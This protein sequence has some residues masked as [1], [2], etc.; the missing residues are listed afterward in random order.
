MIM[1]DLLAP[2]MDQYI[3]YSMTDDGIPE[4]NSLAYVSFETE[5]PDPLPTQRVA[6]VLIEPR[7]LETTGNLAFRIDLIRSLQRFKGDLRADG[8]LTRFIIADLYRGPVHKDGRIVLALRR[9][10]KDVRASFASF[11]GAILIGNFPEASLVRR[12]SWCPGFLDPRQL[13]VG[14]ELVSSRAEIVLA[15][16][17]GNWESLYRQNDFDA[18]D[19]TAT[20][21]AATIATGWFDGESVR[22]CNFTATNFTV[23]RSRIF[24]DAFYLDDAIYQIV[25]HRTIPRPFLHIL[26]NQAEQNNEVD[27]SD[28]SLVNI[29]SR[30]DISISRINA[31]RVAV[32]PNPA[33]IGSGGQTFLDAEGA[34]QLV[35]SPTSLFDVRSQHNELFNSH[36]IDLE[37]RLML[38]YFNRNHRFRNGAFSNLPFRGAVISGTSDFNPDSYEGL[39]NNAATDF[40]PCVKIANADLQQ[41]V[42]FHKTPAVLKYIIAH[43][44]AR[45]SEFR[46]GYDIA[47]F[48]AEVGGVPFRWI[49]RSGQYTP[50]FEGMGG[51]A[52][53][54]THRAL[55]HYNTLD[56]AGGCL[57][58]HGGCDVNSVDETQSDAYT[59]G[60]YALWN[61][62]E[63]ILWYTNCVA[64]FSRAK[65]FNDAP[66][67]FTDGYRLSD[68]ANF[69]SCCRS[70]FNAQANDGGL[71][72]YNIQRKR[73][74]FWSING[75][76]TVRLRNK[77]GLG[78]LALAETLQSDRVHP[79]RAWIDGWNYDASVS[80]IKGIGDIDADGVDEF[81][82]TSEWG[83]GLLK[84]N[85]SH[86]QALMTAPRDTWFGGWRYDATINRGRDRIMALRNFTGTSKNEIMIWSSWGITTLEYSDAS[87]FPT[88]IHENGARLG[89]WLVNTADNVYCGSGQFGSD[90][91]NDMVLTS[92]WGMGII[93]LQRGTHV[94]MLPN[95]T[96]LGGWLLNSTENTIHLIAD[97]DGD[98]M[99]EILISSPWGIGL[100]KIMDGSLLAVAMHAN[101][102]NLEG[103]E[104]NN[105]HD[106]A[107]ADNLQGGTR[108][109]IV[110]RDLSGVHLLSFEGNKLVRLAFAGHGIRIDG[111]MIDSANNRLQSAGDLNGD[112]RAE[113]IIRS[114]WGVGIMGLDSTNHFRCHS[115]SPFGSMLQEWYLQSG[116]EIVGS[117]NFSGGAERRELLIAK[118]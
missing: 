16:L 89:G 18:E 2:I 76:W 38:S 1:S 65:G 47:T 70:Y 17:S 111:W 59:S 52:D 53:I 41:Y 95:G 35:N 113:L 25:E 62:A 68:R 30:P 9:F 92:P 3:D 81:V 21:D 34:P 15:D 103:Y 85:G 33:L 108:K 79:N 102:E 56:S 7:L 77:N 115:M 31:Y 42:Q 37:R 97:L 48:T 27:L 13:V 100:L 58:I 39:V 109:Q 5:Y 69:G 88:R 80:Q 94:H 104:V 55:W 61:N 29:L 71:T 75:D 8:L 105:T 112:G 60:R 11:E 118:A 84:Y 10:F 4:I 67:G 64:I 93:S 73:A 46:G 26:L 74:Y 91:R 99:D 57:I 36:D 107:L 43:S 40:Q 20:P 86:F 114:S 96:R 90:S 63:G 50:S 54:F 28:R 106:F 78:I 87:L 117:G 14:T 45:Y 66:N 6:V 82:I 12:V 51:G 23:R 83:I 19:I 32:N 116:D 22:T 98:G 49:Y 110:V 101:G 72:S 24:R 44:D